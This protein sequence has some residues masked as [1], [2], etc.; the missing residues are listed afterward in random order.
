M[1]E[2]RRVLSAFPR[3]GIAVLPTP[4]EAAPRLADAIGASS[5]YVKRDDLTGLAFGGNKT[6]QLD[7]ILGAAL[8]RGATAIVSRGGHQSNQSRQLAAA[9]ARLDLE[10]RLVTVGGPPPANSAND[11]I[12]AL[13]GARTEYLPEGSDPAAIDA[14]IAR[15]VRELEHSAHVVHVL[16]VLDYRTDDSCLGAVAYAEVACEI[17][18][19]LADAGAPTQV[20]VSCG[21]GSSPT[22]AGI[23]AGVAALRLTTRVIGVPA[24]PQPPSVVAETLDIAARALRA[25]ASDA[26]IEERDL[27]LD[28]EF[29][30]AGYGPTPDSLAAVRLAARTEGLLCDPNYTG[31]ALAALVAHARRAG[32]TD[33]RIVFVHTGGLPL[34]FLPELE[35]RLVG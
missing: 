28:N 2:L 9:A 26:Q 8:R 12:C 1:R 22:V 31:K 23:A 20:F 3:A 27:V 13:L 18:E 32:A 24:A 15:V 14:T 33:E 35:E 19:Q 5:I 21:T 7:V 6:R 30:G 10:L 4:L 17:L 34:L 29:S 16:D 11:L 25:F